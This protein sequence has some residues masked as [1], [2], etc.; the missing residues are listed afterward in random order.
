[1]YEAML[2]VIYN[3][4]TQYSTV[5]IPGTAYEQ[6]PA[7]HNKQ[8]DVDCRRFLTTI[9]KSIYGI[10]AIRPS[11]ALVEKR[12]EDGSNHDNYDAAAEDCRCKAA[13]GTQAGDTA[14]EPRRAC[15]VS[16]AWWTT[17]IIYVDLAESSGAA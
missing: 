3:A 1:M 4:P 13:H 5:A 2:I 14:E 16:L 8:I 12:N 11:F 17:F 10:D 15:Y 7:V 9:L 6:C